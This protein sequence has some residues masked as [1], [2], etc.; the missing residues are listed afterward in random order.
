MA[1]S[2]TKQSK[3]IL[4]SP[5]C[6]DPVSAF[7]DIMK[8]RITSQVRFAH[9]YYLTTPG[10][11]D[12]E[13]RMVKLQASIAKTFQA[14]MSAR[15][16]EYRK[17]VCVYRGSVKANGG[18]TK[19]G[20]LNAGIGFI[21]LPSTI[22]RT[23]TGEWKGGPY[24]SPDDIKPTSISWKAGGVRSARAD[25]KI[26]AKFDEEFIKNSIIHELA[27]TRKELTDLGIPVELPPFLDK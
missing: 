20:T 7:D 17:T 25:V 11:G 3:S 26:D 2:S 14:F 13:Q 5:E 1:T 12:L 16:A 4:V 15:R 22:E 19:T 23:E 21:F 24:Y 18:S 27:I 8:G 10:E 9:T 6:T